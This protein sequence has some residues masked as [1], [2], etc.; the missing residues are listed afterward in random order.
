[1]I[2]HCRIDTTTDGP[3]IHPWL[4]GHFI[5]NMASC[6]YQ[7]GLL[8]AEGRP[9][10]EI[11]TALRAMGVPLLRWPGGLFADGYDW[12]DGV[13]PT[14]PVRPNRYW[15]RWGPRMGP[16]DPNLFGTH[17]FLTLCEKFDA[18][19][20]INV[21]MGSGTAKN[22]GAWVAYCNQGTDT[23]AGRARAAN[24]REAP[25]GVRIW[26]IGN[27]TYG[28][29]SIGHTDARTYA[30][31]YRDFHA[32]MT[33]ADPTIAPVAV[34]ACDLWPDWN[35]AV[36]AEIGDRA[37]YLSVHVYLPGNKPQYLLLR[38][39]ATADCHYALAAA[40][41]EL[42][43]KLSV[44]ERQIRDA[45]LSGAVRIALDEWNLWWWATQTYKT[46]W[47]M[48]DA[49]AA[50]GMIGALVD[51]ADHVGMA[52]IAQAINV[53][54][55][56]RTDER[57]VV[58]SPI[59][60]M[61]AGAAATLRGARL[62]VRTETPTFSTARYGGIPATGAV[63]Y[64]ETWAAR[65]GDRVGA[66]VI[67]RRYDDA[68]EVRLEWPGVRVESV[69]LLSGPSPDARNDWE[70]PDRAAP[71]DLPVADGAGGASF[72]LPAASIAF[73]TGTIAG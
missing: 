16:Q 23:D 7:G 17:E 58:L 50:A 57:R 45:G 54:G 13:G 53:L 20:Y 67:Q 1:M 4:F 33:D 65:D 27:E 14:R 52:N 10:D 43:R 12:R 5:E 18:E 9:R 72:V 62:K 15:R 73:V 44:A 29:W 42:S 59:Y 37:A 60:H 31:R 55:V 11:V 36:L 69:R 30:R 66:M 49:V 61:L 40:G 70:H 63:P 25:F 35:P 3:D 32:A 41:V 19:P 47:R 2:A 24:G 71:R 21:N 8:D 38:G 22:A 46:W 51:H 68:V 48:R 56:I 6:L 64:V 28:F 34:G 39:P 26:G